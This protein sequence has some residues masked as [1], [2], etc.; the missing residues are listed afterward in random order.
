VAVAE[1]K[2]KPSA[3]DAFRTKLSRFLNYLGLSVFQLVQQVHGVVIEGQARLLANSLS[4]G[5]ITHG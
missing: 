4:K 5:T 1:K 3:G 2:D